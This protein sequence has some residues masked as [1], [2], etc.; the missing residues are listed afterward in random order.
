MVVAI[1]PVLVGNVKV[2]SADGLPGASVVSK[3]SALDP[4]NIKFVEIVPLKARVSVAASPNVI[5]PPL[6]VVVPVTV[7]L[8]ATVVFAPLIVILV[9]DELPDFI[10]NSPLLFVNLPYSVPPSLSITS[11]PSASRFTS[12]ALS[13]VIDEPVIFVMT[14]F[15]KVLFVNVSVVSLPTRVSVAFGNDT[16]LSAVGSTT[17]NV[18]SKLSAVE[19]SKIT[20]PVVVV[21]PVIAGVVNAGLVNVLFVKVSVV[22]LPTNVSLPELGKVSVI[23]ADGLPGVSVVSKLSSV[24]PSKTRLPVIVPPNDTVSL[25]LSPSVIVEPFAVALP[26]TVKLPAIVVFA[27]DIVRFIVELLPDLICNSPELFVNLPNSVPASFKIISAPSA[28]NVM[29]PAE[30]NVIVLPSIS[31]IIGVVNVLFV[32]VCVLARPTKVSEA[33]A[34]NV[35]VISELGLPGASVVSKLSAVEPSKTKL[36]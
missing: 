12:P 20:L 23:S 13:K 28:S 25:A 36:P 1:V 29:S 21:L 22:A 6:N 3:L 34:G 5:V 2:I 27:P 14:G 15:V 11:A 17:V 30:S 7:K 35:N 10:C 9:V 31:V 26:V 4:S 19:P 32:S 8:P 33:L 16:V 18:V 24:L